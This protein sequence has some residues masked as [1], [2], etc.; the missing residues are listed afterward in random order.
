MVLLGISGHFLSGIIGHFW[1][2]FSFII[3]RVLWFLFIL[4][5]FD[6]ACTRIP[7][8]LIANLGGPLWPL[9]APPALGHIH[10]IKAPE[11]QTLGF[12]AKQLQ[13]S[14]CSAKP[15][16]GLILAPR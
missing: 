1:H 10:F 11:V 4:F 16:T 9:D 5:Y 15:P 2:F 6:A 7:S 13:Y 12:N 3:F 14:L 8:L